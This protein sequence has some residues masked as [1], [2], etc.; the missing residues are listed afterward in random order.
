LA[1]EGGA[2]GYKSVNSILKTKLDQQPR[3]QTLPNMTPIDHDNIRGGH[4]YH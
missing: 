1:L 4:Y 2:T 3:Q